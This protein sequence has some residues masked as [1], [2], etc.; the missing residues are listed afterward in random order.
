MIFSSASR[1]QT[2]GP[3]SSDASSKPNHTPVIAG[4]VIAGTLVILSILLLIWRYKKK[5]RLHLP[6]TS[7][8]Q[9][10]SKASRKVTHEVEPYD[11]KHMSIRYASQVHPHSVIDGNEES[12]VVNSPRNS[13]TSIVTTSPSRANENPTASDAV[14]EW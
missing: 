5:S 11:L 13:V 8:L 2:D 14:I 3:I 10:N 9:D 7:G 1:T 4:S 6:F 12:T